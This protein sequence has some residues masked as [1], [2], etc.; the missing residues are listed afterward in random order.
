MKKSEMVKVFIEQREAINTLED[1]IHYM[2]SND[3]KER[4][5]A[6]YWQTKIRYKKLKSYI[7]K[8]EASQMSMN[9]QEP[10][11]DCPTQLLIEQRKA[12]GQYLHCLEIRAVIEGIEL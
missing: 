4:F 11:H 5:I 2:R 9:V 10:P 1:T 12:M 8:I 6:E 7:N 3:Y